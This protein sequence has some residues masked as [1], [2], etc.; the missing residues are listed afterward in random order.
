MRQL[1]SYSSQ[2]SVE[3]ILKITKINLSYIKKWAKKQST[4]KI[5]KDLLNKN[6][7]QR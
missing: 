7:K 5:L 6:K 4:L 3:S 2:K 1:D